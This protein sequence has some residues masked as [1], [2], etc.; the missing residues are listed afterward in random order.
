MTHTP[1]NTETFTET[2]TYTYTPTE[3]FTNTYTHTAT[4]TYTA[5]PTNTATATYTNTSVPAAT[6]TSTSSA[7]YINTATHTWTSTYTST[8]TY[9]AT[10][11]H[12]PSDTVTGT[13]TQTYVPT[14]THTP[15]ATETIADA[16][17]Q[18][19]KDVFTYPNPY[20][21]KYGDI[22][23]KYSI[24]KHAGFIKMK[25]YSSSFRLLKEIEIGRELPAG[26]YTAV[27]KASEIKYLSNGTYYF[28]FVDDAGIKS[29]TGKI[30][31]IK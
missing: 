3:T 15:T 12:T 5:T 10:Y 23:I 4:H 31:L 25:I 24:K 11:T 28:V 18:E 22:N 7:T 20:N 19:I 21:P 26:S 1:T 2:N 6:N 17:E 16:K 30:L 8:H 14:S 9:T 13:Y 29:K 27:V